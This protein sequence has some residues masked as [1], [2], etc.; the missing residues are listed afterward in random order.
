VVS[1]HKTRSK[2][3]RAICAYLVS[4]GA[5]GPED[6]VPANSGGSQGYPNTTVHATLSKPEILLTGIRRITTHVSIKGSAV[7]AVG[8]PNADVA[9]KNFDDRV[10]AVEDALMQSDDGQSL[11]ATAVAIT[12]AGRALATPVDISPEA[13]Q[14]AANNADMVDFSCQAWYDGGEGDG[15]PEGE[16]CAY[17]EILIFEAVCSDRNVD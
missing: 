17:N 9:R 10:A 14:F 6:T 15:V 1:Y 2:L 12:A 4:V 11:R 8:E 3:N 5:G 7:V 16:G 13:A